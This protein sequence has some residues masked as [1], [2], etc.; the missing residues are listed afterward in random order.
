MSSLIYGEAG[1]RIGREDKFSEMRSALVHLARNIHYPPTVDLADKVSALKGAYDNL[2]MHDADEFS[3][4]K[5]IELDGL[6][7]EIMTI[8]REVLNDNF[9][10]EDVAKFAQ[11]GRKGREYFESQSYDPE[12]FVSEE[13]VALAELITANFSA[14]EKT[15]NEQYV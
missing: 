7:G 1:G 12:M 8:S 3:R 14:Y 11:L 6:M 13:L 2:M 10:A 5:R 9:I 4:K 15:L